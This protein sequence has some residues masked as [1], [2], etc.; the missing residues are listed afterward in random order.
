M[1][2]GLVEQKGA[3]GIACAA[4]RASPEMCRSRWARWY[5]S[6]RIRFE[7][8]GNPVQREEQWNAGTW[9]AI[10][11]DPGGDPLTCGPRVGTYEMHEQE[12]SGRRLKAAGRGA[13]GFQVIGM[14]ALDAAGTGRTE[15]FLVIPIQ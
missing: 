5:C 8:A 14:V 7:R 13:T 10:R 1:I 6:N 9:G 3:H 11:D 4:R 2:P 12:G 15:P